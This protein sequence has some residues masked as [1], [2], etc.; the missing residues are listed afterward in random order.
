MIVDQLPE[1]TRRIA[2]RIAAQ[3]S[4]DPSDWY[5]YVEDGG[6]SSMEPG[7]VG[8]MENSTGCVIS[9][10]AEGRGR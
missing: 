8:D 7:F 1:H 10:L 5:C 4:M 9:S 2:E 3:H 6:W